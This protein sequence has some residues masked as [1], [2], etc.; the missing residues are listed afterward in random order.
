MNYQLFNTNFLLSYNV[1]ALPETLGGLLAV[2][3]LLHELAVD[4]VNVHYIVLAGRDALDGIHSAASK[5][6]TDVGLGRRGEYGLFF[7]SK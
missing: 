1:D 3:I 2:Y 6:Q 7:T 4:A 5:R